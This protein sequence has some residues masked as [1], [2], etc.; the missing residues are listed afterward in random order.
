M[1][2]FNENN[3]QTSNEL[4]TEIDVQ[5]KT[6]TSIEIVDLT[7]DTPFSIPSETDSTTELID[8]PSKR[9]KV[10]MS[11]KIIMAAPSTSLRTLKTEEHENYKFPE[12]FTIFTWNIDGLD[13]G[14]AQKRFTAV[15]QIIGR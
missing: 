10:E 12:E 4:K 5:L 14:N 1:K 7:E 3:V 9:A 11:K 8:P 6:E 2:F 15:L 13:T